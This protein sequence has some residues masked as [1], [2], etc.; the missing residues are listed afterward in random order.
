M[1]WRPGSH[2]VS[3]VDGEAAAGEAAGRLTPAVVEALRGAGLFALHQPPDLGGLGLSLPDACAAITEVS[4][5]DGAAGWAVMI[6]SGPAWFAGHMAPEGA[7]EVFAGGGAV[8][9]SGTLGRASRTAGGWRVSGRWRWCSGGPWAEWLTFNAEDDEGATLTVALPASEV[10]V[11]DG[12]WDVRGLRG[13]A[14]VDVSVDGAVVPDRRAFR[15]GGEPRRPEPVFRIPFDSFAQATMAAVPAGLVRRALDEAVELA[16][17]KVPTHGSAP[18]ADDAAVRAT[19]AGAI[20]AADAATAGLAAATDELWQAVVAGAE[21]D[22]RVRARLALAAIHMARTGAAVASQIE[23]VAGMSV[24]DRTSTLG[25]IIAD[26]RA[27]PANALLSDR[28]LSEIDLR[29]L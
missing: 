18:V 16:V 25:R 17:T 10:T 23:A 21:A 15:V 27:A 13:S 4:A 6:G 1:A 2:L 28:R 3:V 12:T 19:V 5:L 29:S 20:G 9:G 22:S 26:L 11:H 8:A 7:R 24:L 14:S